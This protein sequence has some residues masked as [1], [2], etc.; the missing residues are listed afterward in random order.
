MQN[1]DTK[2]IKFE[3][4]RRDILTARREKL[5][6][7]VPEE[8]LLV[9]GFISPAV[10]GVLSNA[11]TIGGSVIPLIMFVD[12]RTGQVFLFALKVLLPQLE[13]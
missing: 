7:V 13:I 6:R 12:V 9:E 4:V 5:M 8:A 2:K 3:D 1:S 10:G 11:L